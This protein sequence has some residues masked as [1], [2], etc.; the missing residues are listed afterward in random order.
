MTDGVRQSETV[1]NEDP[2]SEGTNQ[3]AGGGG[4]SASFTAQPWQQAVPDWSTGRLRLQTRCGRRRRR[5]RPLSRGWPSMTPFPPFEEE[6]PA[7]SSTSRSNGGRSAAPASPR[8]S[9][10]RCSRSPAAPTT[11]NTRRKRSIRTSAPQCCTTSPPAATATATASTR[12]AVARS[13]HSRRS[14]AATGALICNAATGYDG[15]TGV[16]TPNGIGAFKP[17][18]RRRTGKPANRRRPAP[19]GG[20]GRQPARGNRRGGSSRA[21][22]ERPGNDLRSGHARLHDPLQAIPDASAPHIRASR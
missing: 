7:K 21:S 18:R 13:I 6:A 17:S 4:C 10:P 2:D 22:T 19:N 8:R 11:S 16:G 3:G 14:T 15:P 20:S 5:R 1:W 12:P 9:S